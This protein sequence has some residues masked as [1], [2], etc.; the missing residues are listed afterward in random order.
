[1]K[2]TILLVCIIAGFAFTTNLKAQY[3][4]LTTGKTITVIRHSANGIMFNTATSR[5]VYLYVNP[6]TRDTFYGR[7]GEKVNGKLMRNQ[8]GNYMY[9][10]DTY[11]YKNGDYQLRTE[12]N[13]YDRKIFKRDGDVVY[14]SEDAKMKKEIDGDLKKKNMEAKTKLETD[15]VI[16]VKDGDYKLKVDAEGNLLEK[17]STFKAKTNVDGS[18]KLKDKDADYKGKVGTDGDMKEKTPAEKRKMKKDKAKT[19]K[20]ETG[21]E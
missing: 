11:V 7:T 14:K 6:T 16:K 4:E 13:N 17:D 2:K 10:A 12:A 18:L 9:E 19:K 5:P 15:G 21:N 8:I 1:M 3:I 20:K